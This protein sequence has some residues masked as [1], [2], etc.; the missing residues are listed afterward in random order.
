M[1]KISQMAIIFMLVMPAFL[2]VSALD[3]VAVTQ[4][5]DDDMDPSYIKVDFEIKEIVIYP[6]GIVLIRKEA[7]VSSGSKFYTEFEGNA[8]PGCVRILEDGSL[9]K[10]ITIKNSYRIYSTSSTSAFDINMLLKDN[11]GN[12]V[13][14][15][16]SDAI[17]HGEILGV[18]SGFIFLRDVEFTKIFGESIEQR[19]ASFICLK[20]VD[21]Q[22]IILMNEPNL[23]DFGEDEKLNLDDSPKTRITWEDTGGDSRKVTLIYVIS[24]ISWESEYFLDTF[25]PFEDEEVESRLEHWAVI[26]NNLDI[27]LLDV[28]V[29]LVAGDIK[30]EN[31]GYGDAYATY[32]MGVAQ[33]YLN[34]YE[35]RS[36]E[37]SEPSIFSMQEFV[38][39]TIPYKVSLIKGET[40]K[41]QLQTDDVEIIEELVY[42]A[43]H[44]TPSRNTYST[45]N[46]E[47][48]GKV[49]KIL[50]IKNNGK[51]WP[52]GTVH[53]FQDYM[54]IGQDGIEWTPKGREAKVTIGLSSD[55]VAKKKATVKETSPDDRYNDDYEYTITILL[56]NYKDEQVNVKVF[57]VFASNALDLKSN[58]GFEEKPGNKMSW[59]ITLNPGEEK[60]IVYTYETRD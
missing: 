7:V 19:N 25:T 34:D 20:L 8:F 45:W 54:L 21:I 53:V 10:D 17:Y 6:Y 50:K 30:L 15:F 38:V 9:V 47:E 43:T 37:S 59:E 48:V 14:L 28:N 16:T 5:E 1:K 60:T 36:S 52:A 39:Y 32:A 33:L 24:G 27:D 31:P 4:I 3:S 23:P 42:D 51:T 35:G 55:I 18:L 41:I 2:Q 40:K 11:V 22:N 57:D 46:G 44:F 12:I 13:E 26:K 29:R 56:T 49:Q 58:P